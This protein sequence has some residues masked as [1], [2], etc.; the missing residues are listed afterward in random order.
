M[1]HWRSSRYWESSIPQGYSIS[2]ASDDQESAPDHNGNGKRPR[3]DTNDDE[4]EQRARPRAQPSGCKFNV[5]IQ[6]AHKGKTKLTPEDLDAWELSEQVRRTPE[7]QAPECAPK[8]EREDEQRR[9]RN[10]RITGAGRILANAIHGL[11]D[12]FG[13]A[14]SY[15]YALIQAH[16]QASSAAALRAHLQQQVAETRKPGPSTRP[17]AYSLITEVARLLA[18]LFCMGYSM[19]DIALVL[20]LGCMSYNK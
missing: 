15:A 5:H 19:R 9:Q 3:R 7:Y 2:G 6:Y 13:P 4:N 11:G 16:K 1:H 14:L 20:F 18:E 12:D 8:R 17:M 10:E